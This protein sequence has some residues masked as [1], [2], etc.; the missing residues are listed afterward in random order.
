[1]AGWR[2]EEL[3]EEETRAPLARVAEELPQIQVAVITKRNINILPLGVMC[4]GSLTP[5]NNLR[6]VRSAWGLRV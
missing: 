2:T 6:G 3:D 4:N 1:M 5:S